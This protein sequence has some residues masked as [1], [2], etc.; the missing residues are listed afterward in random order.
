MS[1]GTK[2]SQFHF[3]AARQPILLNHFLTPLQKKDPFQVFLCGAQVSGG[4]DD[5]REQIRSV[6]K[7]NMFAQGFL[8]E[9][10]DKELQSLKPDADHLTLEIQAAVR[11]EVIVIFLG[12]PGT[13]S[14][15]TAF[16][17]DQKLNKKLVVFNHI[18]YKDHQSFI[19]KGPMKLL[20]PEQII[21][22]DSDND[23][24][25][26]E[27]IVKH[28]DRAIASRRY[29]LMQQRRVFGFIM[30]YPPFIASA[31]V[32]ACHPMSYRRLAEFFP[33]SDRSLRETLRS[34]IAGNIVAVDADQ[35][36]PGDRMWSL[37]SDRHL[38]DNIASVRLRYLDWA[39]SARHPA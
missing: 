29:L 33:A 13:V 18:K 7:R 2:A 35:Y 22:Y 36:V 20:Q 17:L 1:I 25:P 15:L 6:L 14:E 12:S 34:V 3:V 10:I 9:D 39:L 32:A 21:Y 11:S 37:F 5:L 27:D 28:L 31:L 26:F 38:R 24:I 8:G 23:K 19:N 30:D 16:S 4:P